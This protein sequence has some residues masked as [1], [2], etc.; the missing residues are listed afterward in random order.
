LFNQI[1]PHFNPG[2]VEVHLALEPPCTP[3]NQY[4]TLYDYTATTAVTSCCPRNS[5]HCAGCARYTPGR[6][7]TKR[8]GGYVRVAPDSVE[9]SAGHQAKSYAQ[10]QQFCASKKMK[11]CGQHDICKVSMQISHFFQLFQIIFCVFQIFF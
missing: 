1:L 7:C 10:A 4:I 2:E 3:E 5:L 11:L 9:W 8:A 6:G